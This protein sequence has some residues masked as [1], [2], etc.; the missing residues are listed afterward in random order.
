VHQL[1]N[2]RISNATTISK[3]PALANTMTTPNPMFHN[4]DL[5]LAQLIISEATR[6]KTQAAVTTIK[7]STIHS[8]EVPRF[9]QSNRRWS[10]VLVPSRNVVRPKVKA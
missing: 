3:T 7:T 4:A 10:E 1:E 6:P 2:R 9:R 8:R 5:P